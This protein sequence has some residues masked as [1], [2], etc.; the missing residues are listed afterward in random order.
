MLLGSLR[1]LYCYTHFSSV[2]Q[3]PDVSGMIRRTDRIP[4]TT[5]GI[6]RFQEVVLHQGRIE[7][8]FLDSLTEHSNVQVERGVLPEELDLDTTKSED[9]DAYPIEIKIRHL[10]DNEATPAQNR[11][12]VS[13][14]LFRSSLAKDETEEILRT[15]QKTS[16]ST[17]TVRT[18]YMIGC[19]GAHS[20]TRQQL[21]FKMEGEQ[22]D[23]IWGVLDIIP[24]TNFRALL[25]YQNYSRKGS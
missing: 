16:G 25:D 22:T 7:R 15:S 11:T 4:D 14:S 10:D 9:N 3:N 6:S 18:K 2:L 24:V 21:G 20:W 5:P 17:E 1:V 19:D 13:D 12:N 8:F 23:S